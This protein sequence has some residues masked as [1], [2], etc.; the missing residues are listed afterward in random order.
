MLGADYLLLSLDMLIDFFVKFFGF[1]NVF[2][3]H[4][5]IR[6]SK[7]NIIELLTI[8]NYPAASSGVSLK[9]LN[10]PRGGE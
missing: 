2:R 5:T 4:I 8:M 9:A 6:N 3:N 10:A 7:V 1:F